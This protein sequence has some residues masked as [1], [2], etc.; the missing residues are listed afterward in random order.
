MRLETSVDI[1]QQNLVPDDGADGSGV[2][3]HLAIDQPVFGFVVAHV[4]IGR[5]GIIV[6]RGVNFAQ[7]QRGL[8]VV[9]G[10]GISISLAKDDRARGRWSDAQSA[11]HTTPS[12]PGAAR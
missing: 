4:K 6:Q 11:R 3:E 12:Q 9:G 8:V 1:A 2:G 10:A 7:D 5:I